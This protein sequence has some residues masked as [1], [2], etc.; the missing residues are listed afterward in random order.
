MLIFGSDRI[1]NKNENTTV[2]IKVKSFNA[3]IKV[4]QA[5]FLYTDGKTTLVYTPN[6]KF[7][8]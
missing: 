3:H 5:K 8:D 6:V 2:L 4:N 1:K 7:I